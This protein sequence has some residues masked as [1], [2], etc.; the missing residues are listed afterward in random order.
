MTVMIR[1]LII[2]F[3]L[4]FLFVTIMTFRWII[5]VRG[6]KMV[7][8]FISFFEQMLNVIA[9][10]MVV[11]QLGNPLRIVIYA[12]GYA[13]GSLTG[14]WL[15]ERLAMGYTIFQII[16][17][18]SSNLALKLREMG[19]GVTV[20][21]AEGQEGSRQV[22]MAVARRKWGTTLMKVINGHDPQAFVVRTDPHAFKGGFLL[23]FLKDSKQNSIK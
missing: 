9:I 4:E 16:T 11:S 2:I 21:D 8:G 18:P 12:L 22:L 6:S 17:T 7:A 13:L 14:S 10:G 19:L 1:D 15:E 5:L 23:K 3:S 20:W